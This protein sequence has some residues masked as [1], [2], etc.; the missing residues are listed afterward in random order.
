MS[1]YEDI[2]NKRNETFYTKVQIHRSLLEKY[3]KTGEDL[4]LEYGK[5]VFD[6]I[7]IDR[8]SLTSK[9]L[10]FYEWIIV[11]Y[12]CWLYEVKELN[13]DEIKDKFSEFIRQ[14]I[15]L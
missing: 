7:G 2:R 3:L 10:S 13:N 5:F 4:N 1:N 14:A 15:S 11:N 6:F 12:N 8:D 9:E